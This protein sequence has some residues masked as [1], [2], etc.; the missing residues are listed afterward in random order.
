MEFGEGDATKQKSEDK[1]VMNEGSLQPSTSLTVWPEI[2]TLQHFIFFPE[3]ISTLP[4]IPFTENI[5]G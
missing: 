5:F 1:A 3:L 4:Y 2:F